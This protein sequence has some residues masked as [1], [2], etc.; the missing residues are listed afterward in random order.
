MKQTEILDNIRKRTRVTELN[1]MQ[2]RMSEIPVRGTFTLL[3]PT[4]SGKTLAFAIPLLKSLAPARGQVQAVV[5]AP[6]RELVLQIAEVI[7]PIAT[8]LKTVAFYGGH[9]MQEEVNSLAVT[10]DIIVAT[11]GRLLDHIKRGQLDLGT[12]SSLVLDEYDKALELGFA[13]EMKRVCRRLTGLKL[14]IL[15]S[16]TPL[17]AIPEYLP[18]SEPQVIDFSAT[19]TPRRRMQIVRVESPSRDKL[20]TLGDLLHSLPNGR[21]IVFANHRES[22]ERIYDA[23]KKQGLPVGIYH[24]GLD[25]NDRENAIVQL[26]NGSTPILVSTDLGARGL[27]IP[28]LSAVIHYHMPVSPEAWT[29]RNGRTAR[30]EA[31]GDIYVITAEGE[32]IPYYITTDRDYA[33]TGHSADPIR[34]ETATLYFNVGKKE[35]I[36]KGDIVGF[37]IA[38]GG[39]TSDEIGVITLRDHSALVGIPRAKGKSL[40]DTLGRERI[41]NTRA[42]I[43]L[44]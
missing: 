41:K 7:R 17:A 26:A 4:G 1:P 2:K 43:S 24:G 3:A 13:D 25:Q 18:A 40:V 14:V 30:Q 20:N 28:E 38:K 37:L 36:S 19:D 6:S 9:S 10:P 31:K 15:T 21:V 23:L 16:A 32:D 29:H 33:P 34:S 42:K 11:P 22:V 5:I 8:G 12:V 35:K 27:D 39:L 44:L